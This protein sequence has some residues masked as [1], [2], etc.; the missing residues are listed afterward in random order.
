M[1]IGDDHVIPFFRYPDTAGIGPESGYVPPVLDTSASLA[2]LESNDV[3]P[4]RLRLDDD[5]A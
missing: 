4:G 5:P 2:S 1:I 3:S